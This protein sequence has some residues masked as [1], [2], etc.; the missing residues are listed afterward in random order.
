MRSE[1]LKQDWE[2][3]V[4][5]LTKQFPGDG[6][7]DL[8]GVLLLIGTQELQ[9]GYIKMKKDVKINVLH[10]AI[11]TILEPFGYYEFEKRDDEGWPHFKSLKPLPNLKAGEQTVL[12]K[13]AAVQY[14]KANGYV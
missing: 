3:L 12:M 4:K 2:R 14:F 7:L 10:I 9:M 11:C 1:E 8:D 5:K 6:D 13:E